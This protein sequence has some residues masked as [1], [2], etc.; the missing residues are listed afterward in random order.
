MKIQI[1]DYT[2][3][4]TEAPTEEETDINDDETTH[5]PSIKA[6]NIGAIRR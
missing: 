3:P 6:F 4:I 2:T 1:P 5:K